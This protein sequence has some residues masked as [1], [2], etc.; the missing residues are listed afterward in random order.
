LQVVMQLRN[1]DFQVMPFEEAIGRLK[2]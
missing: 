2:E 1:S